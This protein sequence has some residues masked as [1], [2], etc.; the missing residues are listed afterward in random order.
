MNGVV[1]IEGIKIYAYHGCLPEEAKNGQE[2]FV[3][4]IAEG[5]ISEA[6]SSDELSKTVDYCVV[7]EIVK[8]EMAIRSK[9]I[10]HVCGRI[11][12]SLVNKYPQIKFYVS[13]KKPNPPVN[14]DVTSATVTLVSS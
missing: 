10:E 3:D 11:L 4:V 13:V 5:D 7:T 6:V 12:N 9:L 1:K 14:G 2:Y 8:K